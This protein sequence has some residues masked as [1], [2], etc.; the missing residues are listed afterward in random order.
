MKARKPKQLRRKEPR[1]FGY[2]RV[3][4]DEQE[5][6]LQ[7]RALKN[8]GCDKIYEEKASGRTMDR[9]LFSALVDMGVLAGDRVVVWKLD[10]LG[11]SL[12]GLTETVAHLEK[13][14]VDLIVLTEK[15]DTSTATGK[16]FFHVMAAMAQWES[17]MISERTKAGIEAKKARGET[18]GR[19]HLIK[20]D[21]KRMKYMRDLHKAGKLIDEHG[22]LIGSDR[23][24]L[25]T[26]NKGNPDNPIESMETVRRWRRAGYPG[27]NE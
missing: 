3:S 23:Q 6:A 15:I 4:T 12:K 7:I 26:L 2:A 13:M 21:P 22:A 10:R 19:P 16:F 24:L 8:F 25:E 17:D 14:G 27:L 20:D 18:M 5:T 1:T 11:R 9:P